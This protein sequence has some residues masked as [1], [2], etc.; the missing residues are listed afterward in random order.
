MTITCSRFSI[1]CTTFVDVRRKKQQ[2]KLKA[3]EKGHQLTKQQTKHL[4]KQIHSQQQSLDDHKS[5]SDI[6]TDGVENSLENQE[7]NK[8][9]IELSVIS[10]GNALMTKNTEF[11]S[12]L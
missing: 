5:K 8:I 9:E 11:K 2:V 12:D 7:A 3:K 10:N 4:L 6:L 1:D